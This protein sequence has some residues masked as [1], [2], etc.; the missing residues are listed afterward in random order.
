MEP[1]LQRLKR[2]AADS[3]YAHGINAE[4]IRYAFKV[5]ER[6]FRGDSILEMGPAEGVMTEHLVAT[7]A[8]EVAPRYGSAGR[9]EHR[10]RMPS[11]QR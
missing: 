1:E 11:R 10:Y 3:R 9:P 7:G 6:H 5:F 2:I 4:T 8:A